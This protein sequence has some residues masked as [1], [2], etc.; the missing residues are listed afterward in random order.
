M[1]EQMY[2]PSNP[3]TD[4]PTPLIETQDDNELEMLKEVCR[5]VLGPVRDHVE[6]LRKEIGDLRRMLQPPPMEQRPHYIIYELWNAVSNT[7]TVAGYFRRGDLEMLWALARRMTPAKPEQIGIGLQS[8]MKPY[9]YFEE[10]PVSKCAGCAPYRASQSKQVCSN[11]LANIMRL[12]KVVTLMS[13]SYG[14]ELTPDEEITLHGTV[15]KLKGEGPICV[16]LN[17]T[18]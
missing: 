8:I 3:T 2:D 10:V 16:S 9:V 1:S 7:S 14:N 11:C 12:Q 6:V 17:E 13:K 4:Q 5:R 18:E 15:E